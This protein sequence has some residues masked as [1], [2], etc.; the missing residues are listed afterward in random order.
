MESLRLKN[1]TITLFFF[2]LIN[3]FV[4]IFTFKKFHNNLFF[5]KHISMESLGL[6]SFTI[7]FF[8]IN[9]FVGIFRFKKFHN[10]LFFNKHIS[11][12][13]LRLKSFTITFF[14]PLLAFYITWMH[15]HVQLFKNAKHCAFHIIV[16]NSFMDV[17][18]LSTLPR[19]VLTVALCLSL[20]AY[21]F[22]HILVFTSL[23]IDKSNLS[24]SKSFLKPESYLL[25][26]A[27][28]VSNLL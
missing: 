1:L 5:N 8:L 17:T 24:C 22:S 20:Q 14:V 13:S 2:F 27:S 23:V 7:I 6:Q 10:N 25:I 15:H 9:T 4:G 16:F 18:K 11:L 28:E 3:T 19:R 26:P 21:N 12:E